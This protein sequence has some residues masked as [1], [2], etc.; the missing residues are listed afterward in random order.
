MGHVERGPHFSERLPVALPAILCRIGTLSNAISERDW[1]CWMK[2]CLTGLPI[3]SSERCGH[4][5]HSQCACHD[6]ISHSICEGQ[7][8]EDVNM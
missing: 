8:G 6:S 2:R 4:P 7:L 1:C 5:P 3:D